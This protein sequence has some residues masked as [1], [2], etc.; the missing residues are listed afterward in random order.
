MRNFRRGLG[1]A[2]AF[3]AIVAFGHAAADEPLRCPPREVYCLESDRAAGA[4]GKGLIA[5]A[6]W[7]LYFSWVAAS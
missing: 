5:G 4:V 3:I 6:F 2:Y 7:P 1:A